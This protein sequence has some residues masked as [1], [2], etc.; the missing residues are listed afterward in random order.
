MA[1]SLFGGA[2]QPAGSDAPNISAPAE[3]IFTAPPGNKGI[4][5][6]EAGHKVVFLSFPFECVSTTNPDP[7][8]QASLVGRVLDWFQ[9]SSG[10]EDGQV[11]RL[12]LEQ[13]YPNPFNPVTQ[14]AFTV[15]EGAGKVTL[16]VHNVNGQVVCTLVD[17]KLPAGPAIAVWDGTDAA[18]GDVASGVYFAR[19]ATNNESAF[20]KMTLLK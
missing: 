16:T 8:N 7:N 4:K 5:V 15:P 14:V 20:R 11:H 1:L 6:D 13:N 9:T 10:V 3:V 18:G 17:E 12:A 19:L 2:F